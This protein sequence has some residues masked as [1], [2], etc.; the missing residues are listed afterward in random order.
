MKSTVLAKYCPIIAERVTLVTCSIQSPSRTFWHMLQLKQISDKLTKQ[1]R[2][3]RDYVPRVIGLKRLIYIIALNEPPALRR[4]AATDK[5][6]EKIVKHDSWPIQPDILSQGRLL[7]GGFATKGLHWI[8]ISCVGRHCHY[9][10][11]LLQFM[12]LQVYR[13]RYVLSSPTLW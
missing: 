1:L 3:I 10:D 6:V 8:T 13:Q 11:C 9:W 4:K 7:M 2:T 5:L 12:R